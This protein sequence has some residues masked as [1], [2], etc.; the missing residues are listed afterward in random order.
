MFMNGGLQT[1]SHVNERKRTFANVHMFRQTRS[2][3]F[4]CSA[5][6]RACSQPCVAHSSTP[7]SQGQLWAGRLLGGALPS[8]LWVHHRLAEV[9]VGEV[10]VVLA[11]VHHELAVDAEDDEHLELLVRKEG[12]ALHQYVPRTAKYALAEGLGVQCT[13]LSVH[14]GWDAREG[15]CEGWG[16]IQGLNFNVDAHIS[17]KVCQHLAQNRC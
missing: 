5:A 12:V 11:H 17:R 8:H 14:R 6:P 10:V 3:T 1:S 9:V 2:H 16:C 13:D 4:T 15:L 7:K